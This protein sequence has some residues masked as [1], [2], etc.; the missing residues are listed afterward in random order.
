MPI[1]QNCM[2]VPPAPGG[3]LPP[4]MANPGSAYGR[5]CMDLQ[6]PSEGTTETCGEVHINPWRP[7]EG[8][9]RP[10]QGPQWPMKGLHRPADIHRR[11][12]GKVHI[13][14][15]RPADIHRRGCGKVHINLWRP[16]LQ[17]PVEGAAETCG[18]DCR[19]PHRGYTDP[20][21]GP[22][23]PIEVFNRLMKGAA[24]THGGGHIDA[25]RGLCKPMKM[26][27]RAV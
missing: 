20:L 22:H 21:Q 18:S 8:L 3:S 1:W 2:L 15:W 10:A 12:C 25:Q 14:L 23:R 17:R 27:R 16:V 13:N 26:Y 4:P 11:G 24:E 19:D 5:C 6:R 9:Q 7:S